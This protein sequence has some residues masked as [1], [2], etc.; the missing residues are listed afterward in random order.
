VHRLEVRAAHVPVRLLAVDR[1][2]LQVDHHGS[3]ELGDARRDVG[4]D[5]G[6]RDGFHIGHGST[7]LAGNVGASKLR[8]G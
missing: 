4:V 3:Q 1:E 2:R 8:L 7:V 6:L 5:G